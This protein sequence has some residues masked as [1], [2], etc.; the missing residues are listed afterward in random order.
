MSYVFVRTNA[1]AGEKMTSKQGG[2]NALQRTHLTANACHKT[3][4]TVIVNNVDLL[5]IRL[6]AFFIPA[7]RLASVNGLLQCAAKRLVLR[8][9]INCKADPCFM[10]LLPCIVIRAIHHNALAVMIMISDR[11]RLGRPKSGGFSHLGGYVDSKL[12]LCI[13]RPLL[14]MRCLLR[15]LNVKATSIKVS[16]RWH[17]HHDLVRYQSSSTPGGASKI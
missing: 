9:R 14:V 1:H 13:S 17:H 15:I 7:H 6:R 8:K 16:R 11:V 4:I 2:K 10:L 3:V 5:W 12:P